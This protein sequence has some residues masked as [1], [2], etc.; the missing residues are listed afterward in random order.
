MCSLQAD[1]I[2]NVID[3]DPE[4]DLGTDVIEEEDED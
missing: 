2:M 1:P 4:E 3:I